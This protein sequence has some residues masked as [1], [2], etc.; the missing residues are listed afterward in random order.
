MD[1]ELDAF[2]FT[3]EENDRDKRL[4]QFV[5]ERMKDVSRSQI[6]KWIHAGAVL[7]DGKNA[8]PANPVVPGTTI[9][10]S[11]PEEELHVVPEDIPLDVLYE[12]DSVLAVNKPAGLVTHP[13]SGNRTGTLLNAVVY[14]LKEKR[15]RTK[16]PQ[17]QSSDPMARM[18]PGVVHRLDRETSGVILIAKN[19][20]ALDRISSQFEKREIEKT[21]H[22]IACG[23]VAP[24]RGEVEGSI[25]K[26]YRS[27]H[28]EITPT[29]RPAKT[30]FRVLERFPKHT[31][32]EVS[33]KTGRT[34]QIRVHLA[35]IGHP[36]LGDKIYGQK[37]QKI[38]GG[39]ANRHLLHAYRIAFKHPETGK[40]V[41]LTAP[42]PADFKAA[43]AKLRKKK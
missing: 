24:D 27:P 36:V 37:D 43:L 20:R 9:Q 13:G 10:V 22:A 1:T 15:P 5:R 42:I 30:D 35:E 33:P 38:A 25:G 8:E 2:T 26:G 34:H 12:D 11:V 21:Y 40:P 16:L 41:K 6:Q 14:Y 7:C 3:A 17:G 19:R 29:G 32:L 28:M 31:Y 39:S 23:A 4:D 18:R